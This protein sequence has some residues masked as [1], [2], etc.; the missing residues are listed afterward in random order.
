[1]RT[2]IALCWAAVALSLVCQI[3]QAQ[4]A[5]TPPPSDQN[6]LDKLEQRLNQLEAEV[7]SR[8]EE[9]ARL[10]SQLTAPQSTQPT[11]DEIERTKQDVLKDLESRQAS[12]LT[13]RT[14]ANFNPDVAVVID[15]LGSW[16]NQRSNNAYNRIDVREAELDLRA[17]I[18][19]R[20]DGVLV[21]AFPRDV[22]NF[23]FPEAGDPQTSPETGAAVEEAYAFFHDFGVPNLTAKLGRFHLRFGRQNVLHLHDL[24]T[25]DPPLV[26]QAFLAPE[27]LSD[28]G[29]SLSYV[30]PPKLIGDQYVELVAEV[31]AGEGGDSASPTLTGDLTVDSPA[32]NLHAL[33][34][35]DITS[36][37]NLE[38]GGSW[39]TAS[40]SA[41]NSERVNLFGFDATLVRTDPT[42]QFNNQLLQAEVMHAIVDQPDGGATQH[43]WGAYVL[44]QQ[45][46]HK[47]WY[48]GVRVDWTQNPNADD[49]EIWAVSPYVSWYWSEFLRFRVEYQHRDGDPENADAIYLQATYIFGAHP[50][51]PYWSMR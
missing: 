32:L 20:A 31:L 33:W 9:I 47:D 40:R 7:K 2:R 6:R 25:S 17:A 36:D 3:S 11:G 29:L 41:D 1:M 42:G 5:A 8:D 30:I 21:L 24:P 26:N 39:L 37:M 22:D 16:S 35:H 14:P 46:I 44:G 28:S 43:A 18:D 10:K 51:H 50:P 27:A 45:Q 15:A 23:P 4:T 49:Q 34:N 13:L 19:P 38:L 12:P 48:A